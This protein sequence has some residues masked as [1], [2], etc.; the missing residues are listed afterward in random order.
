MLRLRH[1]LLLHAFR[2]SDQVILV[3]TLLV[4][5]ATMHERGSFRFVPELLGKVYHGR[6]IIGVFAVVLGWLAI[7][8]HFVH[9]DANRFTSISTTVWAV[10]KATT[11]SAFLLFLSGN[12][13][14]F[15][16]LKNEIVL[17]F[18]VF[19]TV[20]A[21]AS[22]IVVRLLLMTVRRSGFNYRH[23]LFVGTNSHALELAAKVEARSELGYRI[24]GFVCEAA[25]LPRNRTVANGK[26]PIVSTVSEIKGHLENHPV[27]EVMICLPI[28]DSIKDVHD[29]FVLCRELGVVV[30]LMPEGLDLKMLTRLQVEAFDGAYVLTFFRES[31]IWQLAAKRILDVVVSASLLVF[32]SPVL[33]LTAL[34]IKTT[35]LG[36]V[37][38]VQER[39]GMNKRKF[40]MLKFRSMVVDAEQKKESLMALNEMQGPAFKIKNDP[41]VTPL[42]RLL[43]KTSFDELPQLI[44]VLKGEMALVGPRPPLPNEVAKYEW[45]HRRRLSIKPG[46][47]CLWQVS[48]RNDV[49]FVQWMQMDQ[50]YVENWSIWL[51]LKILLKTIPVVFFGRGAS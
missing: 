46:I 41:R 9:Y 3:A 6:E 50:H 38:F 30:R 19:T 5:V 39:V 37:F 10:I 36:P 20:L 24:E 1:K 14:K 8:N 43:R 27:D 26:W 21:I 34:L 45:L 35:S 48:G 44:N 13:F 12:V 32:L 42:G 51:D 18:W 40:K 49:P 47:T 25:E 2:I 29:V 16:V 33:L 11:S 28:R 22:R 4:L 31:L 15:A 17:F 7:F 23:I